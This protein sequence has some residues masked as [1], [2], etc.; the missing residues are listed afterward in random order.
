[1]ID[2]DDNVYLRRLGTWLPSGRIMVQDAVASGLYDAGRAAKDQ[3]TSVAVE[4][5]LFPV[6]MALHASRQAV[7]G[8]DANE[9]DRLFH[10]SIHRH[11]HKT[12]WPPASHLHHELGMRSNAIAISVGQGCNGEFLAMQ[13]AIEY[14]LGKRGSSVL[15][16]GA[17][18]FEQTLFDR[19]NS[20]NGTVYG[21]GAT[22]A[23]LSTVPGLARVLHFDVEQGT[24]LEQMYRDERPSPETEGSAVR[25]YD[26]GAAKRAYLLTHGDAEL[27]AVFISTLDR[28]RDALLARFHLDVTPARHVIFP[29]VGAGISAGYYVQAFGALAEQDAW[30]FG[31]SIGHTGVSDQL[32]GLADLIANRRVESGDRVLLV[33]AGNGLSAAVM[34]LEIC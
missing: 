25:D 21:D 26:V 32:L 22:A 15:V 18:C 20:D 2:I 6:D 27:R 8:I 4:P 19:W 28:L 16:T 5:N 9:L 14:V 29:N 11:G 1:M 33:G 10:S 17:D 30:E 3:F 34:L 31:R 13:L 12:L 23:L 7:E 24:A